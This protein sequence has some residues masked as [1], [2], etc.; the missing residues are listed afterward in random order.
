M[1]GTAR[2]LLLHVRTAWFALLGAPM[3]LAAVIGVIASSTLS[4]YPDHNDRLAYAATATTP[5]MAAFNGRTQDITMPGAIAANEVGFL[6]MVGIPIIFGLLAIMRTRNQEDHGRTELLTAM[7][8]GRYAPLAGAAMALVGSILTFGILTLGVLALLDFPTINA[9][10]YAGSLVVYAIAFAALG[11]LLGDT[12]QHA[13]TASMLLV[14]VVVIAYTLRA[15]VD[16]NDW[17]A[18]WITPLGWLTE[19]R[20]WG[21]EPQAWPFVAYGAVAVA[22]GSLTVASTRVRDLG[23]GLI[24]TRPGPTRA[25]RRLGTPLGFAASLLWRTAL[26]WG[27]VVVLW[28]AALGSLAEQMV[29]MLTETPALREVFGGENADYAVTAISVL[30]SGLAT[31]A[32]GLTMVNHLATEEDSGRL[33]LVLAGTRSRRRI[34]AAWLF[35]ITVLMSIVLLSGGLTLGIASSLVTGEAENLTQAMWATAAHLIAIIF[36][37]LLAAALRAL[38]R[39][40]HLVVWGV[41]GW[42]AVVGVLGDALGWPQW[43]L[44]LSPMELVGDVP[45]ED[46]SGR[47]VGAFTVAA[48][49][50]AVVSTVAFRHRDLTAG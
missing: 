1:T 36:V 34:W 37:V 39:N 14:L 20:P 16:G 26:G 33:G 15:L 41:L 7:P 2:F 11:L 47:A 45:I 29:H 42:M 24:P 17:N 35:T 30:I 27:F 48:A 31:I 21:E 8:V 18:T 38:W 19:V 40:V 5:A 12:S 49:L 4:L 22:A 25:H 43:A 13:R 32:M 46:P 50:L 3:I 9:A 23:A 6:G 44:N 10:L 28:A